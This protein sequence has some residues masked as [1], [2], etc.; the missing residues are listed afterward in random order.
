MLQRRKR[1][2]PPPGAGAAAGAANVCGAQAETSSRS[3]R[4]QL[5]IGSAPAPSRCSSYARSAIW[6]CVTDAAAAARLR[7]A[8][9][10]ARRTRLAVDVFAIVGSFGMV[11]AP[12]VECADARDA[13]DPDESK[14]SSGARELL[15]ARLCSAPMALADLDPA[16]VVADLTALRELTEDERGAQRVAWTDTWATARAW[17]RERLDALPVAVDTDEAGNLW[18]VLAGA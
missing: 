3:A 9:F 8:G 10:T 6:S 2:Q 18:A 12:S 17:L 4:S 7:P 5:S 14:G 13:A 11:G 16:R 15:R 1:R